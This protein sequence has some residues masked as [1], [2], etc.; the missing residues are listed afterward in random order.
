MGLMPD[1]FEN[2]IEDRSYYFE[3]REDA[4]L[5][6]RAAEVTRNEHIFTLMDAFM[7]QVYL[8]GA[9]V[10]A[11]C[12]YGQTGYREDIAWAMGFDAVDDLDD[13]LS[14]L[15]FTDADLHEKS[16]VELVHKDRII[17]TFVE[18]IEQSRGNYNTFLSRLGM[19]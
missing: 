7:K 1:L 12:R 10:L 17:G 11:Y 19:K 14:E 16:M 8:L 18:H 4:E 13:L 5:F 3:I 6:R 2:F 9:L 15:G